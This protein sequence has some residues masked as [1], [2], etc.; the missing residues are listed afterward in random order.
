MI[1]GPGRLSL[2]LAALYAALFSVI[3]IQLPF[4][5]LYL[6]AKGLDAPQIGLL[7]A[8]GFLVKIFT[9]PLIGQIVDRR[10]DR[11]RP[12]LLLAAASA[13]VLSGFAAAD[14]F[15]PLLLLTMLFGACFSA[16][17]PLTDSLTMQAGGSLRLDYGRIRLWGSLSFIAASGL[18]GLFLVE[19]PPPAILWSVVAAQ[20][21]VVVACLGLPDLRCETPSGPPRPLG[22]LMADRRFQVFLA[23]T[24]AIQISHMIYYGFATLHW[25]AAGLSGPLIG[26]LWAEGVIAEVVLFAFGRRLVA[27][28]GPRRLLAIAGAAGLLRWS[29]LGLTTDPWALAA[30]QLLHAATFG[31]THL[32]AMHF[33]T[34]AGPA[35]FSARAQA[36]YASVTV[37]LAPGLAMLVAGSLYQALAGHAFLVMGAVAALGLAISFGLDTADKEE[38]PPLSRHSEASS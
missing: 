12:L 20:L 8:A 31:A 37:G 19:A 3:G 24:S 34:A 13:L 26:A 32:G 36:L 28:L 25:H 35:G 18:A 29:V 1:I 21:L 23:T 14:G 11:R 4:W 9:N 7:M 5:P 33:I 15:W 38:K 17:M 22:A 27:R 2:R 16:M 6:S 10:G 30:A